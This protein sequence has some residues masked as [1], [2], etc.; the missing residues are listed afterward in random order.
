MS[1]RGCL[2]AQAGP[3]SSAQRLADRLAPR[4][5]ARA[6][7]TLL[8]RHPYHHVPYARHHVSELA[9]RV[10]TWAASHQ[11]PP[12]RE[13]RKGGAPRWFEGKRIFTKHTCLMCASFLVSG[14]FPAPAW[15]SGGGQGVLLAFTSFLDTALVRPGGGCPGG[16]MRVPPTSQLCT[17]DRTKYHL[18]LSTPPIRRRAWSPWA[19]SARSPL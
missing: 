13:Q 15:A 16:A 10:R 2:L 19:C 9:R 1:A 11:P 3:S 17:G 14:I 18:L 4:C 6:R 7:P 8:S 5:E 12:C